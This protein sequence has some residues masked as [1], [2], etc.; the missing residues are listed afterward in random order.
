[1]HSREKRPQH[2]PAAFRDS[3]LPNTLAAAVALLTGMCHTGST[4]T[5]SWRR[6]P[7]TYVCAVRHHT[8]HSKPLLS[9]VL[10]C[11]PPAVSASAPHH[12]PRGPHARAAEPLRGVLRFRESFAFLGEQHLI[13][14]EC[15]MH[16]LGA[17]QIEFLI[18]HSG[19]FSG[20][21]LFGV[22]KV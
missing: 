6:R 18:P 1:M 5:L 4:A 14:P 9:C 12:T 3:I 10:L 20:A 17:K 15:L 11:A 8:L 7:R 22:L 21:L 13:V 19:G 2:N 16:G